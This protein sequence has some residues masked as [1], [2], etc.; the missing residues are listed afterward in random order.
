VLTTHISMEIVDDGVGFDVDWVLMDAARR[1]RIGL[2]G[3]IERVRLIGG[4]LQI[5]SR[6]GHTKLKVKL[7]HWR[8]DQRPAELSQAHSAS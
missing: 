4:D 8:P 2:L 7:A 3:M 5:D 6:P 1:G